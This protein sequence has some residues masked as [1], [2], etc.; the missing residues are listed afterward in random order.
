MSRSSAKPKN[1]LSSLFQDINDLA[2][3]PSSEDGIKKKCEDILS[4]DY[5]ATDAE[6][7]T[8]MR[9][10]AIVSSKCPEEMKTKIITKHQL[11]KPKS[12][13]IRISKK[14]ANFEV[15]LQRLEEGKENLGAVELRKIATDA[16]AFQEDVIVKTNAA[17]ETAT[18]MQQTAAQILLQ[19]EAEAAEKA[20]QDAA[21]LDPQLAA[22]VAEIIQW[23][24]DG[25]I[26]AEDTINILKGCKEYALRS[27]D[28]EDKRGLW[29]RY[30]SDPI[31]GKMNL[32]WDKYGEPFT[33]WVYANRQNIYVFTRLAAAGLTFTGLYVA[34]EIVLNYVTYLFGGAMPWSLATYEWSLWVMSFLQTPAYYSIWG[35]AMFVW[36]WQYGTAITGAIS[37][38]ASVIVTWIKSA[39]SSVASLRDA[40]SFKATFDSLDANSKAQVT[41]LFGQK[42]EELRAKSPASLTPAAQNADANLQAVV[43]NDNN[44]I[45][46]SPLVNALK[47]GATPQ[48][49]AQ[50][51]GDPFGEAD[52]DLELGSS[53]SSS[54]S[55]AASRNP[56]GVVGG[57]RRRRTKRRG[58]KR[59]T[60]RSK[61][62][63]RSKRSRR[64]R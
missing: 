63:K 31:R 25:R 46:N 61:K 57:R 45:A 16:E 13:P 6:W 5:D 44:Q 36:I 53:S 52:P 26:T 1:T 21:T 35:A 51:Q 10:A 23:R 48:Q 22:F 38:S 30:I 12:E 39:Y 17:Q 3:Q 54:S 29:Q 19:L 47:Q 64:N 62:T 40:K 27:R 2:T 15:D 8:R 7:P 41:K 4:L 34:P 33:R 59:S 9:W 11:F 18:A 32:G 55:S 37:R 60:K 50:A 49:A 42:M 56:G 20:L 28:V 58:T 14:A 24:R 43:T